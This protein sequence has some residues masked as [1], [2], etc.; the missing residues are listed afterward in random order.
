MSNSI[1]EPSDEQ[2]ATLARKFW[3]EEGQPEG[4]AEEHWNRAQDQLRNDASSQHSNEGGG[5]KPAS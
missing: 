4:K 3:E 5:R 2:I 1:T